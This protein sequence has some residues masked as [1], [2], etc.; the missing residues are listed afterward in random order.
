MTQLSRRTFLGGA[1]TLVGVAALPGPLLAKE[2][3]PVI[4][5]DAFHDDSAGFAA[6]LAGKPFICAQKGLAMA[7]DG[8]LCLNGGTFRLTETLDLQKSTISSTIIGSYLDFRDM[9]ID[10][11]YA[12][13]A[14]DGPAFHHI[15]DCIIEGNGHSTGV[16]VS[17]H[18]KVIHKAD[19]NWDVE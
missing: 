10:Q 17:P 4:W 13:D 6:A 7:R 14:R 19:G 9:P 15:R 2:P 18:S 16:I 1:L 8:Q 11:P 12:I 3:L 5:G